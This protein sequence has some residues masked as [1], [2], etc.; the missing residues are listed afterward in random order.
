MELLLKRRFKGKHYTIGTLSV[1]G[2]AFC[3]V[4]ELADNRLGYYSH[5]DQK[6]CINVTY[7][8]K[9]SLTEMIKVISH[10]CCHRQQKVIIDSIT[11]LEDMG[12]KCEKIECFSEA[13]AMKEADKQYAIDSLNF[14]AY[15]EN[16][17]ERT[18]NQY[19][20]DMITMLKEKGLLE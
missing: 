14:V 17:L 3:A 18:S 6:L 12:I 15:K 20:E 1:D 5:F 13:V 2:V 10:E 16:F 8:A 7:M 9:A 11:V 19:A 4:K